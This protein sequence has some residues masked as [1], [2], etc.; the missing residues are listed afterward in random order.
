MPL[1]TPAQ[2]ARSS[3]TREV[4]RGVLDAV[5]GDVID[6]GAGM[7]RYKEWIVTKATSYTAM[8][9]FQF[10]GIDIVGDVLNP[11]LPDA[12]YDTAVSTHVIEHVREPWVMAEQMHRVLKPG[13]TIIIMAP[14]MYPFHADPTDFFR[15]SEQGIASLF[16]R[17]GMEIVLCSKYGGW[18]DVVSEVIKQKFLSPY[19]KPHAWWRRR[20]FSAIE[21]TLGFFNRF[22]TPGIVYTNVVCIARKPASS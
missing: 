16:E 17:L 14:F 3:F 6:F 2:I 12:S 20:T 5:H 7:S 8:D 11:P 21:T 13:G 4:M 22:Y 18:S 9:L 15:F 19:K 1:A 10:P